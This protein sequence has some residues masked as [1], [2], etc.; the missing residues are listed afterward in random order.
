MKKVIILII[1]V[2]L[3]LIP[4][5]SNADVISKKDIL[6]AYNTTDLEETLDSEKIEKKFNNYTPSDDKI[7]I[8][9]FRGEGCVYCNSFLGFLN[10]ITEEYGKYFNLV[11]FEVWYDEANEELLNEVADL[12]NEPAY[13]V[14]YIV[15]G[16]K[17]FG[18]YSD[19]IRDDIKS[20]II[21]EYESN[22]RYDVIKEYGK[23]K[24]KTFDESDEKI[25]ESNDIKKTSNYTSE[26]SFTIIW[27]SSLMLVIVVT[28]ILIV[29]K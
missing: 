23:T 26:N 1:S 9:L 8:Y 20:I 13:G 27:I 11:S 10:D 21:S 28:I 2:C 14:P 18:G 29:K 7:N 6:S 12:L 25:N 16:K 4:M 5:N 24:H 19:D 15:I 17:V 22:N 3:L